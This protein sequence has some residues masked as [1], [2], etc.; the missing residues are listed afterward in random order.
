MPVSASCIEGCD[1]EVA[2]EGGMETDASHW[3]EVE[4]PAVPVNLHEQKQGEACTAEVYLALEVVPWGVMPYQ[5]DHR[6]QTGRVQNQNL[7][8]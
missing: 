8:T 6:V 7:S 4:H 3:V 1:G 5:N 2:G